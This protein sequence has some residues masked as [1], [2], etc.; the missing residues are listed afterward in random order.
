MGGRSRGSGRVRHPYEADVVSAHR[1]PEDMIEYGKRPQ[2]RYSRD[3]CWRRRRRSPARYARHRLPV[4]GSV[5]L[6][7]LEGMDCAVDC[8]MPAGVPVATVPLTV[9]AMR[10]CWLGILGSGTDAFAQQV[11]ADCVSLSGSAP[12][13][14]G[15]EPL[16]AP[17]L[18]RRRL[19]SGRARGGGEL[20]PR[21]ALLPSSSESQAYVP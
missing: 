10:V 6:K 19:G 12:D 20:R 11:H 15:L 21:P 17:E 16:C 3:Y 7:N 18:P 1:M 13:R 5:R 8:L 4:I 2:P 14:D 9:L